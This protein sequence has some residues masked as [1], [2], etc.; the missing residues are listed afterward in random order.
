MIEFQTK[1]ISN[2]TDSELHDYLEYCRN[3]KIYHNTLQQVLKISINLQWLSLAIM[4]EKPCE[5]GGTLY[6]TISCQALLQRRCNDYPEME[7]SQAVGS[8][9]HPYKG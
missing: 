8:A 4:I 1:D 2:L 7:Y 9:R 5:N 3:K 6:K